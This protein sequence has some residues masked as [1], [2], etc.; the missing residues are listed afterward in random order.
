MRVQ[1]QTSL[2]LLADDFVWV[3]WTQPEPIRDKKGAGEYF[4]GWITATPDMRVK[5]ASRVVGG[6]CSRHRGVPQHQHRPDG[7]GRHGDPG[8]NKPVTG[9]GS[10]IARFRDGKIVEYRTH[11][12]VA[13]IMMQLGLMPEM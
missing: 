4:S 9:R 11:L 8:T 3:D 6:G 10:Y 12:D 5:L 7:D 1:L 2:S 13:G